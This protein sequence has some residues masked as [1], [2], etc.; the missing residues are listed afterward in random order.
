MVQQINT[1]VTTSESYEDYNHTT[2]D[3]ESY[4]ELCMKHD[5]RRFA[6]VFLPAFYSV[7]F[8]VG[9]AGNSLVVAVYAYY[10]KMKTK[11]DVYLLNLAVADLLLLFTLP[12]WAVD[13]SI[14]WQS[15]NAM[16]KITSAL[17]T[18]NFSS[19]MQFL[20]C[21]SLD[22]YF[23]VIKVSTNQNFRRKC[24]A[25]CF[26]VWITSVLLC[27][28]DLQFSEVKEHNGKNA[29]LP[30]YP[31]DSVKEVTAF[32]QFLESVCCFVIPFAI[33]L[34]CYSA[35]A[36]ILVKTPNIKRSRSLKV[37]LAVVGMF[38]ITQLPY[39]AIKV[40]RAIDIVYALI[41]SCQISKT[42]DI[43][44]QVTSSMALFH[45]CLNPLLYA[46][47][48]TTFKSYVTQTVKKVGSWRRQRTQSSEEYSMCSNNH[49]EET[50]SFSI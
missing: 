46:Y 30:T 17:Y 18:I 45:C 20:A 39:N 24:W 40:W 7:A 36:R 38:L 12:F 19:G 1:T 26:F 50:D 6:S 15:G 8:V 9:I 41:T 44:M 27:I 29:C 49:V 11:T 31:K 5:I 2:F 14:G 28:P 25:I 4:E 42:L 47:M 37:L 3:Y 35:I 23:A 21:I 48:G 34:F 22:R 43:M 32:I 13:A 16:C 10:K 33:M